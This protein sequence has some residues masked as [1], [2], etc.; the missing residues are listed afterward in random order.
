MKRN[1]N[2]EDM[3]QS[4]SS[5]FFATLCFVLVCGLLSLYCY[6]NSV[7]NQH[8]DSIFDKDNTISMLRN[9]VVRKTA[10]VEYV[11]K[12][13]KKLRKLKLPTSRQLEILQQMQRCKADVKTLEAGVKRRDAEIETYEAIQVKS[14]KYIQ[15]LIL[16]LNDRGNKNE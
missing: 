16:K 7:I 12:E 4:S 11:D 6:A 14:N 10:E 2:D 9:E 13:M 3:S 1:I 5:A 8:R 15:M